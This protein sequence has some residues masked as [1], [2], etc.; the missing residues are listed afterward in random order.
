MKYHSLV[1]LAGGERGDLLGLED[2]RF[3]RGGLQRVVFDLAPCRCAT[4]FSI[5]EGSAPSVNSLQIGHSRSPKYWS[6]TGAL[7]SPSVLPLWGMPVD[8]CRRLRACVAFSVACCPVIVLR[9]ASA[10]GDQDHDDGD[11]DDCDDDAQQRAAAGA[12]VS[13]AAWACSS[14]FALRARLLAALLAGQILGSS[15]RLM[16]AT[17]TASFS[18]MPKGG[19]TAIVRPPTGF[20]PAGVPR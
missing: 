4:Y 13:L 17:F 19:Q 1:L 10:G 14:A 7:G 6:V 20:D 8:Q 12:R 16:A 3:A 11:D 9:F 5:S 18:T 2:F 15:A